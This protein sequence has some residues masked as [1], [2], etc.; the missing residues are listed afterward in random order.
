MKMHL[1]NQTDS[2]HFSSSFFCYGGGGEGKKSQ[3]GYILPVIP[4][5]RKLVCTQQHPCISCRVRFFWSWL[6]W[7]KT[8]FRLTFTQ[9]FFFFFFV[10]CRTSNLR[11]SAN[12]E[13]YPARLYHQKRSWDY[14]SG[15]TIRRK[16]DTRLDEAT[17]SIIANAAVDVKYESLWKSK[18]PPCTPST[19]TR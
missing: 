6:M 11:S 15:I 14:S 16:R 13:N 8:S 19:Y 4:T 18:T 9:N 12:T 2:L 1:A 7:I 3:G 17:S 10:I 5:Y